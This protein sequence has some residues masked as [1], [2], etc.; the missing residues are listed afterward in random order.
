MKKYIPILLVFLISPLASAVDLTVVTKKGYV[1]FSVPDPWAVQTMETKMPIA[2]MSFQIPNQADEGTP[3]STNLVISLYE[4]SDERAQ[5]AISKIGKAF[6]KTPPVQ[7]TY[8][9]WGLYTQEA[10]QGATTYTIIDATK[11]VSDVL[12]SVRIAWPHLSNNTKSYDAEMN[13]IFSEVLNSVSGGIGEY[14]TKK[15]EVVRRPT[16]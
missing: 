6:G 2:V 12:V 13:K 5:K 7:S 3:D 10:N 16:N 11:K 4:E 15:G 14:N 1:T 9:E 8:K